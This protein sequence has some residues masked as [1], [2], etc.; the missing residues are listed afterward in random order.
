MASCWLLF[1]C[2][3]VT[4]MFR[5]QLHPVEFGRC[6]SGALCCA[7][8]LPQR[9]LQAGADTPSVTVTRGQSHVIIGQSPS[10]YFLP[11][12]PLVSSCHSF[13]APAR[14]LRCHLHAEHLATTGRPPG[15][16]ASHIP[17]FLPRQPHF[18]L[19]PLEGAGRLCNLIA[20]SRRVWTS[21]RFTRGIPRCPSPSP[22]R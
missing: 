18:S 5:P 21:V 2:L 6:V 15:R 8:R 3:P 9:S 1:D 11:V 12:R 17:N 13:A 16:R 22:S 20:A 10:E 4:W 14:P 7:V 19:Q